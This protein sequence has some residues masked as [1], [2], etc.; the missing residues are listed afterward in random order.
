MTHPAPLH[1]QETFLYCFLLWYLHVKWVLL[2]CSSKLILQAPFFHFF[3][4]SLLHL[5]QISAP[6]GHLSY[7]SSIIFIIDLGK[8]T[9]EKCESEFE[10]LYKSDLLSVPEG[11]VFISSL[12]SDMGQG[13]PQSDISRVIFKFYN[14]SPLFVKNLWILNNNLGGF[15]LKSGKKCPCSV[16][17]CARWYMPINLK[18]VTVPP[19]KSRTKESKTSGVLRQKWFQQH[20]NPW[21]SLQLQI[22]AVKIGPV[23]MKHAARKCHSPWDVADGDLCGST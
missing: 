13:N 17:D 19:R 10:M 5:H 2:E 9:E 14:Y 7:L 12:M 6:Q 23:M 1:E 4:L 20:P 21:H 3:F 18:S 16:Q 8:K 15:L 11:L 22:S